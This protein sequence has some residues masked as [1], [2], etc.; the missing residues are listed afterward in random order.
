MCAGIRGPENGASCAMHDEGE[1]DGESQ[2]TKEVLTAYS[3][4][5]RAYLL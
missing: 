5:C 3:T 2:T 1:G 4:S